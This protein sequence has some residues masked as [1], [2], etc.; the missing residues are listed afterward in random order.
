MDVAAP[1]QPVMA[2]LNLT[3]TTVVDGTMPMVQKPKIFL[4]ANFD[5]CTRGGSFLSAT[6]TR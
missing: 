4:N 3:R 1:W 6:T 2:D 5:N